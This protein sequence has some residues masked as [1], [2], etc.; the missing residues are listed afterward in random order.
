[1]SD[2]ERKLA[3]LKDDLRGEE[4]IDSLLEVGRFLNQWSSP[5]VDPSKMAQIIATV[6]AQRAAPPRTIPRREWLRTYALLTMTVLRAQ[7]RIVRNAIWLS[8][9]LVMVLG[10]LVTVITYSP[11]VGSTVLMMVTPL[12]AALGIAF[13]YGEDIDPPTELLLSTPVSP[14]LVLMARMALVFGFDLTLGL[15]ASL[16]A[17]LTTDISFMPLVMAWLAPMAFLSMLAF[18]MS[19]IFNDPLASVL[20]SMGIWITLCIGHLS[21]VGGAPSFVPDLLSDTSLRVVFWALSLTMGALALWIAGR[22]E[23]LLGRLKA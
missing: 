19:V 2:E 15:L 22:E 17:A 14:R 1:M 7:I 9:A 5:P 4:D 16:A 18:L 21:A 20:I 10:V 11:T 3:R 12:V 8:S 23:H 13:I 6:G